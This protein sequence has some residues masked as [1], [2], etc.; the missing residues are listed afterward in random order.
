MKSCIAAF[1][2]VAPALTASGQN[3]IGYKNSEIL[4]FMKANRK[5]L[6]LNKV[7]NNKYSYLKYTNETESQTI[8]YFLDS[9]SVCRSI[10]M[11]CDA[12]TKLQKIKEFNAMYRKT[13]ENKWI[14]TRKGI[15]YLIEIRDEEWACII[16]ML[17]VN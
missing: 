6:I 17:R 8:L 16:S 1:L 11:I 13:G 3:L 10:R 2:L 15:D 12:G 4:S 9:D 5:D 7:N 14:E